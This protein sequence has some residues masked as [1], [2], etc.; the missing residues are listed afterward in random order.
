M[1]KAL[2][3]A[4]ALGLSIAGANA[5]EFMHSAA[6]TDNMTVAGTSATSQTMS[7]PESTAATDAVRADRAKDADDERG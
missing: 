2:L 6:K 7:T 1:T 3:V 4:A 5:C